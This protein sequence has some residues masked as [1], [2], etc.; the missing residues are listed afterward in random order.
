MSKQGHCFTY[1]RL[2]SVPFAYVL[3]SMTD[4]HMDKGH[5]ESRDTAVNQHRIINLFTALQPPGLTVHYA[6]NKIV[7]GLDL[8]SAVVKKMLMC[9]KCELLGTGFQ[10]RDTIS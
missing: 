7:A 6:V 4:C 10:V 5:F 3:V 8:S 9:N 2:D 1:N